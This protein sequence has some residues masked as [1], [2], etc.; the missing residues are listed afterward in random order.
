M[1]PDRIIINSNDNEEYTK[2]EEYGSNLVNAIINGATNN[3][4]NL[5]EIYQNLLFL[6]F[7]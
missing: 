1:K 6:G 7:L 2:T 3:M 4:V 5:S